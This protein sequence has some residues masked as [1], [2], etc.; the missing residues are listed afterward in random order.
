[1][2]IVEIVKKVALILKCSSSNSEVIGSEMAMTVINIT[3]TTC[4][5][6]EEMIVEEV[7][8][9]RDLSTKIAREIL[10][11]IKEAT[12]TE[13]TVKEGTMV[14]TVTITTSS[15]TELGTMEEV[16]TVRIDRTKTEMAGQAVIVNATTTTM[17]GQE[18]VQTVTDHATAKEVVLLKMI[19]TTERQGQYKSISNCSG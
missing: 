17:V 15:R 12:G 14:E 18:A 10:L 2:E 5:M 4:A 19:D 16:S 11:G 1:M 3:G 8:V 6:M 13:T 7:M 9:D